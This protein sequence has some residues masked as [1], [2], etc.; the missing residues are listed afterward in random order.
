M[1]DTG[2]GLSELLLETM[3]EPFTSTKEGGLGVGLAVSR[4]IIHSHGGRIWA[5]NNAD[6]GADF[7]FTLPVA[8]GHGG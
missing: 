2:P 4:S 6:G 7:H 1:G 8:D 5:E 3:F